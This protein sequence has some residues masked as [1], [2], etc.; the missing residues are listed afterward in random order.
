M[1]IGLLDHMGYGNLGDAATQDAVIANIRKRLPN[2]E[3]IGF[4]LAPHD[5]V[6]RHGIPCYPIRWSY[7]PPEAGNSGADTPD[8]KKRGLKSI[9]KNLPWFY[10]WAKPLVDLVREVRFWGSCYR[11][12]KNLDLLLISGGGQLDELW[13]GPWSHPYTVFKFCL[14]A[15]IAHKPVYLLNIG[16]GLLPHRLSKVFA[17][18]AVRLAQYR[19]FRDGDSKERIRQLGVKVRTHVMPDLVYSLDIGKALKQNLHPGKRTVGLNPI[20]F[21]DPRL[22]PRKDSVV[23]LAYLDKLTTFSLWLLNNGYD[24]R[25]FTTETSVDHYAIADLRDRLISKLALPQLIEQM[26]CDPSINVKDLL[27]EMSGLDF[28]VTSKFHGVIFSHLLEKPVISLSYHRKMDFAMRAVGQE[29]FNADIEYFDIAWLTNAFTSLVSEART[30]RSKSAAF[31]RTNAAI[32]SRQLDELFLMDQAQSN[33][34]LRTA[35]Y[36]MPTRVSK[37]KVG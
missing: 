25:V 24:L 34:N 8:A 12:L 37:A 29:Q 33:V 1:K 3:I 5:T 32:L 13:G 27:V 35:P 6:L 18:W 4:S 26:F 10:L 2:A 22:W 36:E 28:V 23:Y 16:V 17:K 14:L 15:R 20:G 31:A 21:C 11:R 19:S 7:R 9:L 30:V